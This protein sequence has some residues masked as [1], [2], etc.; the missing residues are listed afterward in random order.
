G[1]Q[2][3]G[4]P[5]I[6]ERQLEAGARRRG[7]DT[8]LQRAAAV[9]SAARSARREGA[10][11]RR[12][13][14]RIGLPAGVAALRGPRRGQ[15]VAGSRAAHHELAV[16]ARR[17]PR[18]GEVG[19][20]DAELAAAAREVNGARYVGAAASRPRPTLENQAVGRPGDAQL[21]DL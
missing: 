14:V 8:N 6:A 21:T 3:R 18:V 2:A 9:E 12:W 20:H 1:E 17:C 4:L 15:A 5:A 19:E 16:E 13:Q 7:I 11:S 10:P